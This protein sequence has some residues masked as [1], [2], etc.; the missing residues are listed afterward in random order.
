MGKQMKL[1]KV[2]RTDEVGYDEYEYIICAALTPEFALTVKPLDSNKHP[3]E[4][5]GLFGDP[6]EVKLAVEQ[7]GYALAGVKSGAVIA[8][9]YR[10]G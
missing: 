5:E 7:V 6:S 4:W 3:A 1:W 8:S 2:Y 10:A 9:M